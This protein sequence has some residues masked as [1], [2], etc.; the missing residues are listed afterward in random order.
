MTHSDTYK[1]LIEFIKIISD[2]GC[3]RPSGMMQIPPFVAYTL[4]VGLCAGSPIDRWRESS[5]IKR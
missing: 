1:S 4:S 2:D 3:H 5:D